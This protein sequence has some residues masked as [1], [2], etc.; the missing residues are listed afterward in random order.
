[1]ARIRELTDELSEE[2]RFY[3]KQKNENKVVKKV[4]GTN[5]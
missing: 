1:M 2:E 3:W 4:A 5:I